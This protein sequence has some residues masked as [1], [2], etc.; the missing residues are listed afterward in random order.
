MDD[1]LPYYHFRRPT[2]HKAYL[3]IYE[4][5]DEGT[6]LRILD[7]FSRAEI[8]YFKDLLIDLSSVRN[9]EIWDASLLLGVLRECHSKFNNLKIS[10]LS[11]GK[12][13]AFKKLGAARMFGDCC[14][15]N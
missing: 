3:S 7:L 13:A 9:F 11:R 14:L 4:K 8:S 1:L 15:G 10:G 12:A 2:H 5:L 6:V